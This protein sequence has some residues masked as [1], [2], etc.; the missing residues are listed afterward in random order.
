MSPFWAG[1]LAS[2]AA[3]LATSLGALPA[4]GLKNPSERL[5]N[6][7][8]GFAAG[9]MLAAS[10]FSLIIPGLQQAEDLGATQAGAA[11]I[12]VTAVLL[13][14]LGLNLLGKALPGLGGFGLLF[15]V[16][17][18]DERS[19]RLWLFIAAITLHNFPEG[20]AVGVSFGTGDYEAGMATAIGIGLQNIPEGLAVLGA[21]MSLGFSRGAAFFVAFLSGLAEPVAGIAAAAT[22]ALAQQLLPWGLG[23]AAGAMIAIVVAEIIPDI[24]R[25]SND[26]A[27]VAALMTGLAMM[28]FL[29][30]ALG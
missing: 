11:A 13:G 19:R 2:L 21:A 15:S 24:Q 10:F 4:L 7:F 30:V 9:V 14:G 12:V 25:R 1:S 6:V 3:G 29:D 23:I 20:M 8:L 5:Q 27:A 28:I 26:R 17:L 16:D 22:V 18:Q